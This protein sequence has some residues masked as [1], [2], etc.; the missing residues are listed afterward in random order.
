[1]KKSATLNIAGKYLNSKKSITIPN[2]NL[3]IMLPTA[4][5]TIIPRPTSISFP[6]L[7]LYFPAR[8]LRK[9]TTAI[10][11]RVMKSV[12][13]E[14]IPKAIPLFVVFL[15]IHNTPGI[16]GRC[17]IPLVLDIKLFVI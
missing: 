9:I 15:L 1:M 17:R 13:S 8:K 16:R 3:S 2:L 4:P 12:C 6:F 7:P 11:A 5:P 14:N 10:E